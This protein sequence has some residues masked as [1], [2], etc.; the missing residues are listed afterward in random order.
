MASSSEC[1]RSLALVFLFLGLLSSLAQVSLA[2]RA[3]PAN[4]DKKPATFFEHE[5]TVVIIPGI[6]RVAIGS[7]EVPARGNPSLPAPRTGQY[8]PGADDTFVPNPGLEIPNP[9]QPLIP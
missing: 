5:D 4:S 7:Q 1:R 2:V 9:F 8:L 6:G 3:T